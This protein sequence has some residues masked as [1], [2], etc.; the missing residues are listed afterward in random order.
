LKYLIGGFNNAHA[1]NPGNHPDAGAGPVPGAS[2]H[3]ASGFC[4][5]AYQTLN[6]LTD[7]ELHMYAGIKGPFGLG[8][9]YDGADQMRSQ[10]DAFLGYTFGYHDRNR[11]NVS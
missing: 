11:Q 4:V 6:A 3:F 10:L 5:T 9:E 8:T 2:G 1:E 7:C